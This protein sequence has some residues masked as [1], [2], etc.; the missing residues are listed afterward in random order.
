MATKNLSDIAAEVGLAAIRCICGRKIKGR[1]ALE[2]FFDRIIEEC[3]DGGEVRI[4]NFGTFT[5]RLYR[6]R[7]VTSP[8]LQKGQIEF[9]DSLVLRFHQS[10]G[11]KKRLNNN[12]DSDA[13]QVEGKKDQNGQES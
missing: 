5:A 9:G 12:F 8:A 3:R 4:K 13:F 11:A 1:P 7:K 6:G 2:A 10:V